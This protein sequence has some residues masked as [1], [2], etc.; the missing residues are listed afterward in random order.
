MRNRKTRKPK[1]IKREVLERFLVGLVK[2]MKRE[3]PKLEIPIYDEQG[4]MLF[5]G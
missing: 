5:S 3:N 4:K 2:K 1:K